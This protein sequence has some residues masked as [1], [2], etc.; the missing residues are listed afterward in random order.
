M[1]KSDPCAR[2]QKLY[3]KGDLKGSLNLVARCIKQLKKIL[4][5][6]GVDREKIQFQLAKIYNFEGLVALQLRKFSKAESSLKQSSE[7]LIKVNKTS[8]ISILLGELNYSL[9]LVYVF[10]SRDPKDAFTTSL[11]AYMDAKDYAA[12]IKVK[13]Q[14]LGLEDDLNIQLTQIHEIQSFCKKVKDKRERK[15]LHANALLKEGKILNQLEQSNALSI[16]LQSKKIFSKL[17][18]DR[19]IA[20]AS[21]EEASI[22]ENDDP[23]KAEEL[24]FEA[25]DIGRVND[26]SEIMGM[27]LTK[28]G[29]LSLKKGEFKKG[30]ERLLQGLK[31]RTKMG[32]KEGSAQTLLELSRITMVSARS[33]QDF[34]NASKLINQSLEI[35]ENIGNEYGSAMAHEIAS[36]IN[37]RLGKF[38]MSVKHAKS[39]RRLFQKINDKRSEARILA[40][41]GVALDGNGDLDEVQPVFEKSIKLFKDLNS[42]SGQAEVNYLLAL[43]LL[44]I[45]KSIALEYLKTSLTLYDGLRKDGKE[46]E[47]MYS[48]VKKKIEELTN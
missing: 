38:E 11:S 46:M 45:D 10:T 17:K 23:E 32:D 18:Y 1:A 4:K 44:K 21:V 16:I 6:T 41:L 3:Q 48:I 29:I 12:A 40:Q 14:L 47:M 42:Y 34:E 15:L 19:G 25:L 33:D 24:L 13:Y 8:K 22:F 28:L 27:V 30:K 2:A 7:Y 35:Y 20:E 39:G 26:S 9:G 36:T 43:H 37:T 5:E 31:H